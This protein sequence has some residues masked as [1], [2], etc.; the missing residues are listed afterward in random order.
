MMGREHHSPV[1][2]GFSMQLR[3]IIPCFRSFIGIALATSAL[4][5]PA[6]YAS[7]NLYAWLDQQKISDRKQAA[8]GK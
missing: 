8:G 2:R 1:H 6:A 7:P 4:S 5:S 3:K